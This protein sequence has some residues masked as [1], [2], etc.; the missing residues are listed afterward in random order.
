[1]LTRQRLALWFVVFVVCLFPV[2]AG[3]VVCRCLTGRC[4]GWVFWRL[5]LQAGAAG[6]FSL[7]CAC[8]VETAWLFVVLAWEDGGAVSGEAEN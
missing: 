8:D 4:G 5:L 1:M 3:A 7:S 2:R 6:C